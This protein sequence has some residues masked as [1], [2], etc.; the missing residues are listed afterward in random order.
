MRSGFLPVRDADLLGWSANQLTQLQADPESFGLSAQ[1]VAPYLI[2]HADFAAAMEGVALPVRSR[3]SVA[4]KDSARRVLEGEARRIN[5]LVRASGVA[6][7][8][9]LAR[10]GLTVRKTSYRRIGP[11]EATPGVAVRSVQLSRIALEISALGSSR[12]ALP[13]DVATVRIA[14]WVGSDGPANVEHWPVAAQVS[15]ARVTLSIDAA[16]GTPVHFVA[17]YANRRGELGPWGAVTSTHALGGWLMQQ[18]LA[19]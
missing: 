8:A 16:P 6:N 1:Q 3:T 15:R 9:A 12:V 5:A 10:L 7:D 2:A 4:A 14:Q 19:A 13:D 17:R 18:P 11:P